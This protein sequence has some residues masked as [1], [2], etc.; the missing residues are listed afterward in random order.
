MNTLRNGDK[1]YTV[2]DIERLENELAKANERV[3]KLERLCNKCVE[4]LPKCP[5]TGR[6][7]FM[8][9][10]GI[11]TYGGPF[12]SY[13]IPYMGGSSSE[14]WHKRELIVER[15]DHDAGA[16]ADE[17]TIPLRIV[18]EDYIFD[19]EDEVEKANQRVIDADDMIERLRSH[20]TDLE[21]QLVAST[22]QNDMVLD[23]FVRVKCLTDNTEIHQ[24]CERAHLRMRQNVSVIDRNR[25]LERQVYELK[26]K[27]HSL[28]HQRR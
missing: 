2:A 1:V 7:L 22:D 10:D 11:A 8:I 15:F 23:E 19:L 14:Q 3:G 12:D 4:P 6:E 5:I 17:E 16:W 26:S 24:L 20:C 18:P 21:N 28:L 25:K 13:T 9:I 27:V